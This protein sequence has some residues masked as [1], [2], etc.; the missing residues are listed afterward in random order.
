M[1]NQ[2]SGQEPNNSRDLGVEFGDLEAQLEDVDYPIVVEEL[3]ERHGD[4]IL[5]ME[6]G[7]QTLEEILEPVSEEEFTD[8]QEARHT[9]VGFVDR[10]AVGRPRYSDRD[11]PGM[12]EE[13]ESEEKS[14]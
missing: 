1:T 7:S 5:E 8:L 14:F 2:D 12:G 10:E 11:P 9:I 3:I 13:A 6:G 4:A